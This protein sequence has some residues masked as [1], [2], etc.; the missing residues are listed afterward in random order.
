MSDVINSAVNYGLSMAVRSSLSQDARYDMIA[1][2]LA[3]VE[4]PGFKGDMMSFDE[5][6]DE[7]V[8]TD[9]TEGQNRHTGNP[10]DVAVGDGLFFSVD[11]PTGTRFTRNGSFSLNA[12][13]LLIT[14]NGH[15]VL[16]QNGPITITGNDIVINEAGEVLVD[17]Q[18]VDTLKIVNFAGNN[19]SD[20]WIFGEAGSTLESLKKEGSSYF[21]FEGEA[22]NL[23]QADNVKVSQKTLEQSNI[24]TMSQMIKLIDTQRSFESYH[25]IIHTFMETDAKAVSDVGRLA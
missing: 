21:R 9:F 16:G 19:I 5:T 20:G 10:L 18:N 14:S 3:N 12:D 24:S 13:G 23:P 17:G 8:T 11:T 22:A 7:V 4:T 25:K 6:L 1:N 2:N 15:P